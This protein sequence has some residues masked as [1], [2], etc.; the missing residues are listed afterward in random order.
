MSLSQNGQDLEVI[1]FYNN[2]YGGFFI[3]I[4]S[5]DGVKFSNT[6]LL[7]TKYKWKGICCE[8]IPYS[9]ENL[10]KNRP[11]S[12][13]YNEAV[14]NKTGLKVTFDISNGCD[15]LSGITEHIDKHKPYV[16]LNKTSIEVQTISLL[17]VL[18]NANAPS[19]IEYMS[20]DTE[21]SEFEILKDFDFEKYT[22]GLIDIE[23]NYVEPRR[24]QIRDLLTSNGYEYLRENKEDDC[25][26]HK[27]VHMS[28]NAIVV[29]TRGYTNLKSYNMLIYRNR[30]IAMN[31][32]LKLYNKENYDIIIYHEGNITPEQQKYIQLGSPRLPLIF[33]EI[34]FIDNKNINNC[35]CPPTAT[36]NSFSMGYKNMCNFW[37]I[38]FL[39]YLKDYDYII[40]IDEDC[41]LLHIPTNIIETYKNNNT[42]FSSGFYQGE[43]DADVTIGLKKLFDVFIDNNHIKPYKHNIACPY[44]N[45]MVVNINY[46]NNNET[47]Q[48]VLN[49]IKNSNCIFSNRW[50]DLPIWGYI[51]SY[52]VDQNM[53][54]EDKSIMYT[55]DSHK[56]KIN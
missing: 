16:E 5:N 33:K 26:K 6:Y 4:G 22:F 50:G 29:L 34:K 17:D 7:E 28:K 40:R 18:D 41:N 56:K 49:L 3:E 42:V 48:K 19:F 36:S 23:H 39:N 32:Y 25:Y 51:L 53:Y 8:P 13:C 43:D 46:F 24:T 37:S 21:G 35:L 47:V 55:H 12:I 15:M 14:Y 38:D 45:F 20:L 10:V 1:K 44:T 2:K 11:N 30:H 31:F 52:L 9:F 27:S 54:I